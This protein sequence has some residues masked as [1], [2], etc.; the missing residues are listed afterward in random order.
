MGP[1]R[2]GY[3]G[4]DAGRGLLAA[5]QDDRRRA[6]R[7]TKWRREHAS[8]WKFE[9]GRN[10]VRSGASLQVNA[11]WVFGWQPAIRLISGGVIAPETFWHNSIMIPDSNMSRVRKFGKADVT[12]DF[13]PET[14][15]KGH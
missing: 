2:L 6:R 10:A 7:S 12:L 8:E 13:I 11:I 9:F 4:M 14:G 1:R 15:K 5:N 3:E